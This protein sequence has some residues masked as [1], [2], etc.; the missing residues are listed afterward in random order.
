VIEFVAARAPLDEGLAI[1]YELRMLGAPIDGPMWLFGY[2]K[3]MINSV[4]E[5]L[6][7]LHKGHL[8]LSWH[9]LRE[10]V[11]MGIVYYVHV[12]LA[13]NLADCLTKHLSHVLLW[14]LIKAKLFYQ[15]NGNERKMI[16]VLMGYQIN[17]LT[18]NREYQARNS[19]DLEMIVDLGDSWIHY[20]HLS[21]CVGL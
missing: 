15:Y 16:E 19:Q 13:E 6:G 17:N 7:H 4:S 11:A 10:K 20:L 18:L 21:M 5:P 3:S 9:Q 1:R 14:R 8:L 2:N 12:K